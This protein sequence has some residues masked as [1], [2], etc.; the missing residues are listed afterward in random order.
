MKNFTQII[1]N[2]KETFNNDADNKLYH[3]F[4]FKIPQVNF[5]DVIFN[6]D[7]NN[8]FYWQNNLTKLTFLA[9]D[10]L[11]S[12][13][14]DKCINFKEIKT[15]VIS[16]EEKFSM[17]YNNPK[18]PLIISSIKFCKENSITWND[19][20]NFDFF[21][22]K[23]LLI[24]EDNEFYIVLNI[25]NNNLSDIQGYLEY[26]DILETFPKYIN[27]TPVGKIIYNEPLEKWET[28]VNSALLEIKNEQYKKVVIAR[29]KKIK[30]ETAV[31][32]KYIPHFLTV[33]G[34]NHKD[35]VIFCYKK[36]N[37]VF[38]G[39]SP[40][41]FL[42]LNNNILETDALAGSALINDLDNSADEMLLNDNKN[43][44]EHNQVLEYIVN[45]LK[46]YATSID[47]S[48]RPKIKDLRY[49]KHLW[50]P[51]TAKVSDKFIIDIIESLFPTPAVCGFPKNNA[52]EAIKKIETESRGLYSGLVG[53]FNFSGNSELYVSLRSALLK[54]NF[55]YAFAGCGIVTGSDYLKEYEETETK[56]TPIINLVKIAN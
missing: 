10:N 33:L 8:Y 37:S 56:F 28:K 40:E 20:N 3:S 12:D 52:F 19:F 27:E 34:G 22:P 24:K 53:W 50:T 13:I 42:N 18:I 2:I 55:L 39:A 1:D 9:I 31:D 21:I 54:E 23:L 14:F 36:G 26:L 43:I 17:H 15:S 49:I 41:K 35:C 45:G 47:Y 48:T 11:D 4:L 16:V 32:V 5:Y 51:I 38:F 25:K 29:V 30:F 6:L 7:N 44:N 46:E